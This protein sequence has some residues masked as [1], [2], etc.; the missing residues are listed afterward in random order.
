VETSYTDFLAMNMPIRLLQ[1][2]NPGTC[3]LTT[4]PPILL[5]RPTDLYV[6][7]QWPPLLS[8]LLLTS[9]P[10]GSS[11]LRQIIYFL[12]AVSDP[13]FSKAFL[14]TYKSFTT[15]DELL[16]LLI[17]RFRI[18]PPDNLTS[19]E[20]EEWGKLKQH[21]IQMRY[22][23]LLMMPFEYSFIHSA[24]SIPSNQ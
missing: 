21:V 13:T 4:L 22:D 10:V 19:V 24:S 6:E 15:L 20:R 16:D 1:T 11:N 3:G 9:K 14:M 2:S 5:S 12:T 23:E 7:G 18:Q 17:A 8:V